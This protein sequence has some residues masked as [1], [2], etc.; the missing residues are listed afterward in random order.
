MYRVH[1][2]Q[3]NLGTVLGD[4]FLGWNTINVSLEALNGE[5]FSSVTVHTCDGKCNSVPSDR[6]MKKAT[7][8]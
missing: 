5:T 3:H 8:I 1:K 7:I 6:F 2:D 4:N